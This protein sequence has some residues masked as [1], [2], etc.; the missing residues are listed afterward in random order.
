MTLEHR[1]RATEFYLNAFFTVNEDGYIYG[2]W[3]ADGG[4]VN[5]GMVVLAD[6][7][8]LDRLYASMDRSTK[9]YKAKRELYRRF[10]SDV[11][12]AKYDALM[13]QRKEREF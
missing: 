3:G 8:A 4:P 9:A 2:Y 10:H 6:S 13:D 1:K 5:S 11:F 12:N 7:E